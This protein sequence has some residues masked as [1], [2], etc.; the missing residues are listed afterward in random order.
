MASIDEAGFSDDDSGLN[1]SQVSWTIQSRESKEEYTPVP[2]PR[3]KAITSMIL[4]PLLV[5]RE[6]LVVSADDM[7]DPELKALLL[8]RAAFD[9]CHCWSEHQCLH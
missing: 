1:A 5:E 4:E 8:R 6:A 7:D 2:L 9:P 3:C